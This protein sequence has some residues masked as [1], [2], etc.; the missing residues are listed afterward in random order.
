M[1]AWDSWHTLLPL[2]IGAVG[3]GAFGFYEYKLSAKTVDS[4]GILLP[5]N[6]IQP[7]IRFSIFR[8]RTL[9]LVYLQTLV[10]GIVLWSLLYF[11]PLYYEGVKEYKP[12]IAGVAVLPETF[13]VARKFYIIHISSHV[14]KTS[15]HVNRRRYCKLQ[16][17]AIQMGY[18]DQLGYN[19][20]RV[21]YSIY[22]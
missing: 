2:F 21:R 20:A 3:I 13:I 22:S 12:I 1:F 19:N 18:L 10:H 11:L 17:W 16:N 15:S 6:N 4:E 5:D 9:R 14:L 7:I 8:N